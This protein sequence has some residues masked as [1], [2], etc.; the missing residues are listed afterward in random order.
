MY[1][2]SVHGGVDW[3]FSRST[4]IFLAVMCALALWKIIDIVMWI[5]SHIKVVII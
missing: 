2:G 5:A 3:L 4:W 1:F